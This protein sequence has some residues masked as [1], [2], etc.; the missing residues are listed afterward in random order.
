MIRYG[1]GLDKQQLLL[2]RL[3]EIGAE[4]FVISASASRS[5]LI[6]NKEVF[7]LADCVYENSKL[8]IEQ[9]FKALK[10]N[11]D[12]KNYS[13]TRKVLESDYKFLESIV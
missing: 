13:L 9:K 11:N 3:A 12:K 6:N 5:Q 2:A 7:D 10:S 4:L 1:P 8:K